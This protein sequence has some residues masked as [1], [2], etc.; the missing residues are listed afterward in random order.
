[1]LSLL[2]IALASAEALSPEALPEPNAKL[3]PAGAKL[4]PA[5]TE[6]SPVGAK[7]PPADTELSPVDAKLSPADTELSPV[8]TKLPPADAE[9]S[10]VGAKLPPADTELSPV[11]AKLPPADTELS[12]VDAKLPPAD[13]ELSSL[14]AE[15]SPYEP[16]LGWML[17]QTLLVLAGVVLLAYILLNWGGKRLLKLRDGRGQRVI[18]IIERVSVDARKGL[19]LVKVANDYFL[20]SNG[21]RVLT[22][23]SKLNTEEVEQVLSSNKNKPSGEPSLFLKKLL[24]RKTSKEPFSEGES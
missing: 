10:P 2:V 6:L 12:P 16:G 20:L 11:G 22:V 8:G 15:L 24:E 17:L 19:L 3:S 18:S 23:L 21:E 7:L 9:L 5:D 13:T 1:M 4:P 14:G